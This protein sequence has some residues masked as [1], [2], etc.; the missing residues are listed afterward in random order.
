MQSQG[1]AITGA[2]GNAQQAEALS[3]RSL[4]HASAST[5]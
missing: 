2:G 3:G 5:A 4:H 1:A